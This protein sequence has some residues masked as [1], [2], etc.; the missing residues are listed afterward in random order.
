MHAINTLVCAY[1]VARAWTVRAI[2]LDRRPAVPMAKYGVQQQGTK[3]L[4][5]IFYPNHFIRCFQRDL[6]SLIIRFDKHL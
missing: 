5:N 3:L 6:L 1:L 2:W 4:F